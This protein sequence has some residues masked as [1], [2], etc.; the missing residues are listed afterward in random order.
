MVN[1][2]RGS[3]QEIWG[4]SDT[5]NKHMNFVSPTGQFI[6]VRIDTNDAETEYITLTVDEMDGTFASIT[7]TR[8]SFNQFVKALRKV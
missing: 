7:L 3:F 6:D 2:G 5:L 1:L 4:V 8:H